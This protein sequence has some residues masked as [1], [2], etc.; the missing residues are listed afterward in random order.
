MLYDTFSLVTVSGSLK[1][2]IITVLESQITYIFNISDNVCTQDS[3][4]AFFY[5]YHL[6]VFD[7]MKI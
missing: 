3:N 4:I 1:A 2:L 6:Y 5:Q 7:T